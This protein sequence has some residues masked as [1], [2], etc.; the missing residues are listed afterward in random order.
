MAKAKKKAGP[1]RF[2]SKVELNSLKG[3]VTAVEMDGYIPELCSTVPEMIRSLNDQCSNLREAI[4]PKVASRL[5][6]LERDTDRISKSSADLFIRVQNNLG[7]IDR[8]HDALGKVVNEN[9]DAGRLLTIATEALE[10]RVKALELAGNWHGFG[11]NTNKRLHAIESKVNAPTPDYGVTTGKLLLDVRNLI[12]RMEVLEKARLMGDIR[13]DAQPFIDSRD[14]FWKQPAPIERD[15]QPTKD[16][17][18]NYVTHLAST[19]AK[20][21]SRS[22]RHELI[23]KLVELNSGG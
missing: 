22:E 3:R 13:K 5:T 12:A 8:E 21:L 16:A 14:G 18:P 20:L 23:T 9:A 4:C 19:A 11:S 6:A 1:A 7:V 17:E 15:A 10:A 2:S